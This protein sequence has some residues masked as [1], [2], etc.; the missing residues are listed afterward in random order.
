[1]IF[2][3]ALMLFIIIFGLLLNSIKSKFCIKIY[4]FLVCLVLFA[5]LAFKGSNIGSDTPVYIALYK[6]L[7]ITANILDNPTRYELGYVVYSKLIS[8]IFGDYQYL[9]VVTALVIIASIN[10][11]VTKYSSLIWMSF[12]LLVSLR[13]YY[14]FLSGLRQTI[15]VAIICISYS[16]IK[17][18]KPIMFI[19]LVLIATMFHN[20]AI[21]FIIAYPISFMSF[22]R[23]GVSAILLFTGII[24]VLF[25]PLLSI[26]FKLI[27]RYYYHYQ[28]TI[29][30]AENNLANYINASVILAFLL[31]G[32]FYSNH[33]YKVSDNMQ[34]KDCNKKKGRYNQQHTLSYFMLIA[35]SISLIASKA[36]M[37]DR[38]YMYFWIFAIIYIPN[39]IASI[40]TKREA[41]FI[42]YCL[43]AL[44]FAYNLIILYYRPEWNRIVPYA[45]FW[46]I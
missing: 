2:Y 19:L 8:W 20:T 7:Q 26:I 3:A 9:F 12:Y 39:V 21:I 29:Q 18:R 17:Q 31:L 13:L 34:I 42:I 30:F 14:F 5:L 35:F 10:K 28:N 23:K 4:S 1:M 16:F 43:T 44:S 46:N 40:K 15:A 38:M 25:D 6:Q 24:Y 45:F 11:L 22:N 37:L 27:P 41:P 33:K 36:S 32:V